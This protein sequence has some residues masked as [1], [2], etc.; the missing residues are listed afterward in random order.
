MYLM[1]II[2][3]MFG[4]FWSLATEFQFYLVL[5]VLVFIFRAKFILGI[6]GILF[7]LTFLNPFPVDIQ[8][9]FRWNSLFIGMLIWKLTTWDLLQPIRNHMMLL[10]N[11]VKITITLLIFFLMAFIAHMASMQWAMKST[12]I[13]LGLGSITIVFL[14]SEHIIF[15]FFSCWIEWLGD[16]SYSWYLCHIPSWLFVFEISTQMGY[17]DIGFITAIISLLVSIIFAALSYFYI[18]GS[19]R[20]KPTIK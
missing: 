2:Y 14:S 20:F 16:I 15:G 18:E 10:N 1:Y 7:I 17:A 19:R 13:G 5:P 8:W 11:K 3:N 9:L 4:Y 6:I 12:I